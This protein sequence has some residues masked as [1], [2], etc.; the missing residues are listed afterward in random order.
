[1]KVCSE[2]SNI[3]SCVNCFS[4]MHM[5]LNILLNTHAHFQSDGIPRLTSNLYWISALPTTA[6][7][8]SG[9]TGG[10]AETACVHQAKQRRGA[11][12]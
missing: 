6:G 3:A 4:L 2:N 9:R 8:A 7:E 5:T 11:H 10:L 12:M 1:M